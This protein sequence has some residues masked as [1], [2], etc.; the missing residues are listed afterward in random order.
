MNLWETQWKLFA[1][2]FKNGKAHLDLSPYGVSQT[3]ELLPGPGFGDFSH[4]TTRLTLQLMASHVCNQTVIDIGCGS[5]ILSLAASVLGAKN[6]Y[7][8][9]IDPEA[10]SHARQNAALNNS[11]AIFNENPPL[12]TSPHSIILMNMI[13]SEQ[14]IAWAS[15]LPSLNGPVRLFTSGILDCHRSHYLVWA[16]SNHWRL[17]QEHEQDGWLAFEFSIT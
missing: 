12:N 3:L 14:K 11:L 4:P 7:G 9:D 5:G 17:V 16:Q 10:I 8:Y 15:F 13:S 1:P 6:V 2:D